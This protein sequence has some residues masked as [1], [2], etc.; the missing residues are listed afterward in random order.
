MAVRTLA[1]RNRVV[2]EVRR[3]LE[4]AAGANQLV[5]RKEAANLPADIGKAVE[6]VR[7]T[8]SRVRVDDAVDAYARRVSRALTAVDTRG[9]GTLSASEAKRI[10]DPDVRA[11][12]VDV[13]AA[14]LR[15]EV[16]PADSNRAFLARL[17]S[18]CDGQLHGSGGGAEAHLKVFLS[19]GTAPAQLT[20]DAIRDLLAP[21]WDTLKRDIWAGGGDLDNFQPGLGYPMELATE[22]M[23]QP[24]AFLTDWAS[25]DPVRTRLVDHLRRNLSDLSVIE[26]WEK[27]ANGASYD[28]GHSAMFVGGR[29]RDGHVAGFFTGNFSE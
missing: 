16:G 1:V 15:G 25:D 26:F 21:Q 10:R 13:R 24:E 27:D 12:V 6:T 8:R 29:T 9:K 2:G 11:R 22:G 28:V 4:D 23:G 3:I 18:L 20:P 7:E 17:R 19:E 14:L 5:S